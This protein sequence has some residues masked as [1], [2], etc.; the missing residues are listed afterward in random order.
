VTIVHPDGAAIRDEEALTVATND[1]LALGGDGLTT[2]VGLP[3]SSVEIDPGK[4]ALEALIEGL[5]KRRAVRPDDPAL[6]DPS[7]PRMVLPGPLPLR[8]PAVPR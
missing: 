2:A 7:R 4:P 1:F 8:C 6:Y 3:D 5:V